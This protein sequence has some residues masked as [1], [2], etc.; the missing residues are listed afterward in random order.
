MS[1]VLPG[2][3]PDGRRRDSRPEFLPLDSE[4]EVPQTK[5]SAETDKV[6]P[7]V[8]ALDR[9]MGAVLSE[10]V[11]HGGHRSSFGP[12]KNR[13][14]FGP[15]V[16]S[17]EDKM[18]KVKSADGQEDLSDGDLVQE[19]CACLSSLRMDLE[20]KLEEHCEGI[21]DLEEQ[22]RQLL[23]P[24]MEDAL[25]PPKAQKPPPPAAP[26]PSLPTAKKP[27]V[28]KPEKTFGM[29]RVYSVEAPPLVAAQES[30]KASKQV[31]MQSS[32]SNDEAGVLPG[33][34]SV[35]MSEKSETS[36]VSHISK[37]SKAS[38]MRRPQQSSWSF[39]GSRPPPTKSS[40]ARVGIAS[41]TRGTT[42]QE[43]GKRISAGFPGAGHRHNSMSISE[44]DTLDRIS[45]LSMNKSDLLLR[46]RMLQK[47]RSTTFDLEE[48]SEDE[49]DMPW[50]RR[51]Y[52]RIRRLVFSPAFDA[53]F[54]FF[55]LLN[56]T[57]IGVQAEHG[58]NAPTE[59]SRSFSTLNYFFAAAFAAEL[60]LRFCAHG[61]TDFIYGVEWRWNLF[62]MLTVAFT[63]FEVILKLA[64]G[65]EAGSTVSVLRLVRALRLVRFIAPLRTLVMMV[66]STLKTLFWALV[67]LAAIL[68][69]F[70]VLLTQSSLEFLASA[71]AESMTAFDKDTLLSN[72]G[73][74]PRSFYTLFKSMC[75]GVS[76]GEPAKPLGDIGVS[77]LLIYSAF[78][79]FVIFAF[80]NTV[81]GMVCQ[82]AMESARR[83]E[84]EIMNQRLKTKKFF[85]DQLTKIFNS[86]DE[87]RSGIMTFVDF[88]D[89]LE[90]E[91]VQACFTAMDLDFSDAFELFKLIDDDKDGE[92]RIEEFIEGCLRFRGPAMS[93]DIAKL[94]AEN[95]FLS[96]KITKLNDRM[97]A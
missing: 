36:H 82:N 94:M 35:A 72:Y 17:A 5:A 38:G 19:I 15:A 4:D 30:A 77:L 69:I 65:S 76:W 70:A 14:S 34:L 33:P 7:E 47:G 79:S 24:A 87:Q 64:T 22:L 40:G 93:I 21:S 39:A 86:I 66:Y 83:D 62:D 51:M 13:L 23:G 67:L 20:C 48:E 46:Q 6:W 89:N 11:A 2:A 71:Q 95:R 26:L 90:N 32:G 58:S 63:I 57:S 25:P 37:F 91:M 3:F 42:L 60:C 31:K 50:H 9:A 78:I 97:A 68:Y 75:G 18:S 55:I 1:P 49:E 74:L 96:K 53:C 28:P 41:Q 73:S 52:K 81:T 85:T 10:E 84:A 54:V 8:S 43:V 88:E 27:F 16:K 44:Q 29:E 45:K 80:L 59:I 92:V 61:F 56:A 12:R